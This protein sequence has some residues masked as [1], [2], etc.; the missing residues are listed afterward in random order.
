LQNVLDEILPLFP[1]KY[2]HI[3]GDECPKVRWKTCPKCQK[4]MQENHLK[5]EH[6]LQSYFIQKMEKY[7]N[8]KGKNLIGWDEILEG[9]LSPKATVMSWQGEAGGIAAAQQHHDVVMCPE[10]HYYLDYYQSLQ[11]SEPIATAGFTSLEKVYRYE[12]VPAVLNP[13]EQTYIKGIQGNTWSEYL[14]SEAQAEYM[15]FQELWRL[16]KQLGHQKY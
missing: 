3:G 2:V 8:A 12:P 16:P 6:E 14:V 11:T 13:T 15:L 4:R 9:G 10:S 7:L 1:S 5:D